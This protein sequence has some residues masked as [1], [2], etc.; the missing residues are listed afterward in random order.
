VICANQIGR[1]TKKPRNAGLFVCRTFERKNCR[2]GLNELLG[3]LAMNMIL[4]I[5][6]WPGNLER[7]KIYPE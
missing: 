6:G 7:T 5:Y 4:P 2:V 3:A 1:L